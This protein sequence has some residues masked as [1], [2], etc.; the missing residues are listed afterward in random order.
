[1][2]QSGWPEVRIELRTPPA[3]DEQLEIEPGASP[4]TV[5]NIDR[6]NRLLFAAQDYALVA[7]K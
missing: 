5:A 2:R 4:A 3:A 1:M 6:L 7:F